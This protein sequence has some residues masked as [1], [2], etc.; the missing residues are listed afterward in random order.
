MINTLL[1]LVET[2]NLQLE[3]RLREAAQRSQGIAGL[4]LL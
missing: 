4:I 1:I 2:A 3:F